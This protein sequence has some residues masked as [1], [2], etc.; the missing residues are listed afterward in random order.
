MNWELLFKDLGVYENLLA[1]LLGTPRLFLIVQTVPFL[2]GSIVTGQ[3]RVA[4][5]LA[6]YLV[7]HPAVLAQLPPMDGDITSLVG[8]Y[9]VLLAKESLLGLL[10]GLLAGMLFWTI[11]SAGFFIDN[12]RGAS[13]ASGNDPLSN[14]QTSPLG[15]FLFQAAVYLFFASGAFLVFL[16][17]VYSSY[18]FWPV[19]SLL[20]L[21][22]FSKMQTSLFFAGQVSQLM[23]TMLLLAGPIVVACLLTDVSLGLINRFASQLN[24]YVL[25]MPIKSAVA[26]FLLLFYFGVLMSGTLTLFSEFAINMRQLSI[27][28]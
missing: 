20:P 23:T 1:V 14:E 26:S 13:M 3:L 10:M 11:Q 18:E 5:V 28:P 8:L 12:Q 27:I 7:L 24:V 16:G 15:S 9:L 25:A 21:N 4:L 22:L 6:C 19:S 17:L 2:A